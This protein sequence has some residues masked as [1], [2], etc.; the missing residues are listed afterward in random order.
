ME[1]NIPSL[2]DSTVFSTLDPYCGYRQIEIDDTDRDETAF[3][4]LHYLF[5]FVR[6][7]FGLK[8]ARSSSTRP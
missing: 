4:S 5:R 8:N 3:T 1:E 6:M 7:P 2:G